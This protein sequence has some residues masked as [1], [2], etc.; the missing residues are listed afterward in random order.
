MSLSDDILINELT[1]KVAELEIQ[2]DE[3]AAHCKRL[4]DALAI[5]EGPD[6][7]KP[8]ESLRHIQ[9]DAVEKAAAELDGLQLDPWYEAVNWLNDY[10]EKLRK[11]DSDLPDSG[12]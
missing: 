8:A 5:Y 1:Q 4:G 2:R 11:G 10:A 12:E 7:E 3:L 6:D 9:A